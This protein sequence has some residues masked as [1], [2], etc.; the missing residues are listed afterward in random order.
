MDP[1]FSK[2]QTGHI[3]QA[4]RR[5]QGESAEGGQVVPTRLL[6]LDYDGTMMPQVNITGVGRWLAKG[7]SR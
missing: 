3:A 2:L 6:L 5:T 1:K 4:Y 7:G